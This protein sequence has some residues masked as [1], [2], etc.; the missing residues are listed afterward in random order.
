MYI[1]IFELGAGGR[2]AIYSDSGYSFTGSMSVNGGSSK[3]GDFGGSGIYFTYYYLLTFMINI[4]E[5]VRSL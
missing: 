2:I 3:S 4:I 5:K 1:L